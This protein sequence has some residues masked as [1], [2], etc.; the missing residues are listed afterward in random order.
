MFQLHRILIVWLFCFIFFSTYVCAQVYYIRPDGGPA[1]ICDGTSD[2]PYTLESNGKCAWSHPFWALDKNGQWK[3][4][5]GDTLI[6]YPGEYMIGY[7]APNTDWCS[8][9]WPWNCKLP[10]I[11]SGPDKNHPTKIVGLG[12]DNVCNNPPE[13]WGT[14]RIS[15]IISLK[16]SKNVVIACLELTDHESCT[17]LHSLKEASCKRDTFP[18]GKWAKYG[19]FASDA[20]NILLQDLNI[21]GFANRGIVA[22]RIADWT[23]KRV[24]I[25]GNGWAGWEGD[26]GPGQDSSNHGELKF[27]KVTIEW[28]GCVESYPNKEEY[29]WCWSGYGDG[30]GTGKTGGIWI[31]E[32]SVFRYNTSDGLDLLYLKEGEGSVVLRRIRAYGNAGNQIKVRSKIFLENSIIVGSCSFFKEKSFTYSVTNCRAGGDAIAIVPEAGSQNI[33]VNN[34]I[35]GEGNVLLLINNEDSNSLFKIVNNIFIGTKNFF[36]GDKVGLIY[37]NNP[38]SKSEVLWK[39][40]VFFNLKALPQEIGD[41]FLENPQLENIDLFSFNLQP[42]KNSF[43]IDKGADFSEIPEVP[44]EDIRKIPRPQ[45]NGIDCGAYEYSQTAFEIPENQISNFY[46]D[47]SKEE[48]NTNN[49]N[50]Y[51]KGFEDGIKFCQEYPDK[52]GIS[53]INEEKND[54]LAFIENDFLYIPCIKN[55]PAGIV[56]KKILE[57]PLELFVLDSIY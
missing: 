51:D 46:I 13:L 41:N 12:W 25:A 5:G 15:S 55:S 42:T 35:L 24:R 1:D 14:E 52:C 38:S 50:D 31:F 2:T 49:E 11:P 17:E 37:W 23:V 56:L 6:I 40:N 54:C 18:F 48:T 10:P 28:N 26:A 9:Y 44:K 21:H 3:I 47:T 32:D 53:T 19:I 20:S 34:T 4:K 8:E 30:L 29:K 45:G 27:Q 39:K 7:G 22:Y 36:N 43:V 33:I 16:N 57:D